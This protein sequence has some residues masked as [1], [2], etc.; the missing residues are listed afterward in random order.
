MSMSRKVNCVKLGSEAEGLD[1][2]PFDGPLGQEIFEKVS[3]AAWVEWEQDMM[4]KII[5]EYRLDLTQEDQYQKLLDQMRAF[6]N[7]SEGSVLEVENE[8]RGKQES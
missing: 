5:N 6:L 2:P 8:E 3:K 7:L 4:M 1:K